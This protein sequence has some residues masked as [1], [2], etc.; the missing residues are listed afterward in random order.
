LKTSELMMNLPE[1]VSLTHNLMELMLLLDNSIT[2][3][4]N[5]MDGEINNDFKIYLK[6]LLIFDINNNKNNDIL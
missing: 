3:K 2:L 5:S 6:N 4:L 1:I